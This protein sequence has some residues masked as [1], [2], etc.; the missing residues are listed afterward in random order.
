MEIE[1]NHKSNYSSLKC[2]EDNVFSKFLGRINRL[3]KKLEKRRVWQNA[4]RP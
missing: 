1:K 2:F 4:L 3:S